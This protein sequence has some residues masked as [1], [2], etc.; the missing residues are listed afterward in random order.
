MFGGVGNR[1]VAL[2]HVIVITSDSANTVFQ[3]R[4]TD[5]AAA[6][7]PFQIA[8]SA[9]AGEVFP[10]EWQYSNAAGTAANGSIVPLGYGVSC[11]NGFGV[12]IADGGGDN[13]IAVRV[14]FRFV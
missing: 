2:S 1:N 6:F 8:S 3:A 7:L 5:D 10:A 11:G 9:S 13:A 14:Y 12:K 4:T